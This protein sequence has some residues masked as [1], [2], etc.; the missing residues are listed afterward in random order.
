MDN[1]IPV[2][3]ICLISLAA[4]DEPTRLK[5]CGHA[6]HRECVLGWLKKNAQCPEC[7]KGAGEVD[8]QKD[9]VLI[10]IIDGL[11]SMN[12]TFEGSNPSPLPSSIISPTTTPNSVIST[13]SISSSNLATSPTN[14]NNTNVNNNTNNINNN[15]SNPNVKRCPAFH[16]HPLTVIL[17][18]KT[19]YPPS[20][21][22]FCDI[23]G[24]GQAG[25]MHHC[26]ECGTFDMCGACMTRGL[27]TTVHSSPRHLHPITLSDP[28]VI[29]SKFRGKWHCNLCRKNN[30]PE[31]F[32]CYTCQDFDVCG[33]CK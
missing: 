6:Y 21:Q 3:S 4:F 24:T 32:H 33:T 1:I 30:Q 2:C 28:N 22:W 27:N 15:N 17:D 26:T 25:T 7:R 5:N 19:I 11:K 29:Y 18:S 8:L 12:I 20:G 23:C 9:F 16:S 31:M 14:T 13:S 10:S